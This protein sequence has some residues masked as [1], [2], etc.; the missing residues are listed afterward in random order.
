[1]VE[2][3]DDDD[4]LIDVVPRARMRTENLLHRS[5]AII[6]TTTDG[7]M[8]V[9]RRADTKDV[10][11]S[12]WDIGAGGVL[13]AGE[14]PDEAAARE[15]YEELGVRGVPEFVAV[16]HYE[17]AHIRERCR[18]YWVVHDGPFNPVDG[19]VVE[20]RAVTPA[21]F[22]ELAAEV[23]F[24]P[25]AMAM[26]LP[27]L[28]EFTRSGPSPGAHTIADVQR[29]EFTIEPFVEA[30]PGPHVTAPIEA[31]AELGIDVEIGPFGSH[32]E[33]DGDRAGEV[34]STVVGAAI[35]NG[36]THI[37]VDV[38]SLGDGSGT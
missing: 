24:L 36:A 31:L 37:N 12:W 16:E 1:M 8:V 10:Y 13:T 6:V 19:E 18:V 5:V 23:P 33:V 20:V 11:P 35:A 14:E 38:T 32:C 2:W 17:D 9:Q 21:E 7:R 29:I 22:R 28:P 3:I 27:H 4:H 25:G 30:Q 34:V 15:L 26:L